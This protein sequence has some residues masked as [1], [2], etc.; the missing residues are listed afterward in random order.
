[1]EP[2]P[3]FQSFRTNQTM[4]LKDGQTTQYTTAA[5]NVSGEVVKIDM[6]LT[7]VK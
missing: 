6:T 4:I 1:V 3:W 5:D 2:A 7:V